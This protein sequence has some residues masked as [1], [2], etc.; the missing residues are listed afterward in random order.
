MYI[1]LEQ[2]PDDGVVFV[3][4]PMPADYRTSFSGSALPFPREDMAF[5]TRSSPNRK[6][7]PER[8]PGTLGSQTLH[9][10]SEHIPNWY[11]R[12]GNLRSALR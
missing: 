5:S 12:N 3:T 8:T 7:L 1:V 9:L 11:Y 4:M 6:S 2:E 10:E